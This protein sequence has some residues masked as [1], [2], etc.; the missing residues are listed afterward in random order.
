MKKSLHIFLVK[1]LMIISVYAL[2]PSTTM[3]QSIEHTYHFNNPTIEDDGIYQRINFDGCI[4]MGKAGEPAL[5]WQNVS[6]LLPLNS[7][8]S[9][10]IVEFSDFTELEGT[11]N[12]L[13]YQ[14]QDLLATTGNIHLKEMKEFISRLI[15]I[16]L[17]QNEK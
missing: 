15:L 4:L 9:D 6:L 8:A 7:D 5:P 16:H 10:I 14:I 11:Y 13:P 2:V 12:L 1:A 3:A 17:K